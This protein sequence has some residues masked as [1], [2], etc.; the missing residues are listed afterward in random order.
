MEIKK[1]RPQSP[2][3]IAAL[4]DPAFDRHDRPRTVAGILCGPA[5]TGRTRAHRATFRS[6]AAERVFE[7]GDY[8]LLLKT[9]RSQWRV[10]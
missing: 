6:G 5:W 2:K 7:Q 4:A 8:L 9:A 3:S 10:P 1:E